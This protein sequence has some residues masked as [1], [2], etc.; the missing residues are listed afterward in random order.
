MKNKPFQKRVIRADLNFRFLLESRLSGQPLFERT[1]QSLFNLAFTALPPFI[2]SLLDRSEV[3]M[4]STQQRKSALGFLERF[5]QTQRG[6]H[7]GT[8]KL[9]RWLLPAVYHSI[10]LY[11]FAT[12]CGVAGTTDDLS[13]VGLVS[14]SCILLTVL[15]KIVLEAS[16]LSKLAVAILVGSLGLWI[17]FVI[18]ANCLSSPEIG[19][20][21]GLRGAAESLMSVPEF[22]AILAVAP[23]T[24]ILPD[25]IFKM[26]QILRRTSRQRSELSKDAEKLADTSALQPVQ[27]RVGSTSSVDKDDDRSGILLHLSRTLP[28]PKSKAC[29]EELSHGFVFDEPGCVQMHDGAKIQAYSRSLH[30]PKK[31]SHSNASCKT[32]RS[33][34]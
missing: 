5:R 28:R 9:L 2:L 31:R 22:W 34:S 29:L 11:L 33:I 30:R 21:Y 23:V 10:T 12:R 17:G 6:K 7:L 16:T 25:T 15:L 19:L 13:S 14:Y 27:I 32:R 3:V 18:A 20:A 1:A 8:M 24:S 26:S 4:A